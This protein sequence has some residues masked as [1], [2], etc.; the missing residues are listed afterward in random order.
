[1][2]K[3]EAFS[4][5]SAIAWALGVIL[6][7][8]LGERLSPLAL[9]LRKNIIVLAM[10]LPVLFVFYGTDWPATTAVDAAIA[11]LSG[12]V[13][14]G[15][16]DTLY[17]RALN[18]LG[19][20]HM[21]IIGNFFSPFVIMLSFAFLGESLTVPQMLGFVLVTT[22]VVI[23]SRTRRAAT[24]DLAHLRRGIALGIAAV[25][26]MAIAIVL[27]KRVL[28]RNELVWISAIRLVGGV[29]GMLLANA[30]VQRGGGI[31]PVVLDRHG[32][33]LL[34]SAAFVGQLLSMLLWLA[35]YKYTDASVAS[36]LNETSSVFIVIFAWLLLREP[37]G[38]A[39][40]V[41]VAFTL[42][43]VAFMLR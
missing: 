8:Q 26:M 34:V 17:F 6:Y 12:L 37:L 5:A 24:L 38:P 28:E 18:R 13:G 35:G 22:G 16:A 36:I 30:W 15:L 32:W 42:G 7:K 39:R 29:I 20:G 43:G 3:G 41:G 1:M 19:A 11:L 23:I 21:G 40:I 9:N 2:G 25:L 4:I 33:L 10:L 27:V 31:A 14:I